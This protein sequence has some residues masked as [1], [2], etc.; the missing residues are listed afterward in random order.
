VNYDPY[1]SWHIGHLWSLSVE[2][3][4][5]MLWPFAF[6]ALG[7]RKAVWVAAGFILLGPLARS[8][9]WLFL[10]GT[11]YRDLPMFPMVADSLAVGCLLAGI[12]PWLESQNWYLR[13]FRPVHSIALLAIVFTINRLAGYISHPWL[14]QYLPGNSNSLFRIPPWGLDRPCSELEAGCVRGLA[15]PFAVSV[16][17]DIPEPG[18]GGMDESVPAESDFCRSNRARFLSV[19]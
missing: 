3:H 10:R 18:L 13:L 6:V 7:P 19:A 16:A 17:A 12:R 2:E 4:F 8:A 11:P 1:R 14:D 15:E 9:S 5:Y